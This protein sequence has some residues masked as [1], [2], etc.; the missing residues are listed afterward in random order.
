MQLSEQLAEQVYKLLEANGLFRDRF[1]NVS[2]AA[3][4]LRIPTATLYC[5]IKMVPHK[6]IGRR[7]IFSERQLRQ[8][9]GT[10]KD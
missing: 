2:E 8:W 9:V 6:R 1:M 3:D 7:V 10:L 4:F 5:M